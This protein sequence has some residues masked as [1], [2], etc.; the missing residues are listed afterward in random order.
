[1]VEAPYYYR[2]SSYRSNALGPANSL[3]THDPL[4]LALGSTEECLSG[5][6]FPPLDRDAINNIR[7][8]LSQSQ[9]VSNERFNAEIEKMAGQLREGKPMGRPRLPLEAEQGRIGQEG[10]ELW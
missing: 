8:A 9:P 1:M 5:S 3:I 7:R 10:L 4:Y 6:V 2:W